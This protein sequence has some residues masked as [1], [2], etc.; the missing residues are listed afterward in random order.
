[1]IREPAIA[2]ECLRLVA[3]YSENIRRSARLVI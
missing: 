2:D 3:S 1:L